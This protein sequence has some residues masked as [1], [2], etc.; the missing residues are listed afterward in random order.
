M[1]SSSN[2]LLAQLGA[3]ESIADACVSAGM[4]RAEF[5]KWWNEETRRRVPD[6]G[7]TVNAGV[8]GD[9]R[10][11]RNSWGVPY[12][13]ASNDADL[14]FAF[15]YAMAQDRLFQL[16]YLRRKG[17]GRVSEILGEDGLQL[18]T[19]SRTIGLNR[20]A[21]S[22]WQNIPDEAGSL[23][24]SF[25][26]GVNALIERSQDCL[27]IEFA[28]LDY[29]PEPWSPVDCL[30]IATEF[31]YYLTVRFAVIVGPRTGQTRAGRRR[32]VRGFPDGR[33][34]GREHI[35][36]RFLHT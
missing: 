19:I 27:P 4:S 25:S 9:A 6:P 15:G 12:I 23:L 20:I 30:A 14:F 3:G 28:L 1:S 33:G 34:R 10:I 31:R 35:A 8:S 24:T 11:T 32:T 26:D 2:G 13:S 16:D 21:Q 29:E 22:E 5:D 17:H 36:G 18:D 7:G